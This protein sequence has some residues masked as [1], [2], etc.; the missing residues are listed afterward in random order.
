MTNDPFSLLAET[1]PADGRPTAH[2]TRDSVRLVGAAREQ[3]P[4]PADDARHHHRRRGGHRDRGPRRGRQRLGCRAVVG[5]RHQRADDHARQQQQR[6]S[7]RRRRLDHHPESRG[8]HRAI[9]EPERRQSPRARWFRAAPRSS[10]A[11]RTGPRA[12]RPSCRPTHRSRTGPSPPERSS[13]TRT[14]PTPTTS[15]SLARRWRPICS[16]TARHRWDRASA[17]AMCR[18]R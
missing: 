18:S 11:A 4:Q 10:P 13:P 3:R 7:R 9:A 15:R 1:P 12:C 5:S 2:R 14:T 17:F 8:R 16:R 6:R